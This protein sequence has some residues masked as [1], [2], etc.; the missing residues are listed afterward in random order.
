[1]GGKSATAPAKADI[2][3][4]KFAS[5]Q[6]ATGDDIAQRYHVELH[7]RNIDERLVRIAFNSKVQ[8]SMQAKITPP[9]DGV[10]TVGIKL[11]VPTN[12]AVAH[13]LP[14]DAVSLRGTSSKRVDWAVNEFINELSR[15]KSADAL[16]H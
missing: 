14:Q 6:I 3:I 12:P 13:L 5:K 10:I 9:V 8:K 7:I 16:R 11:D 15:L 1:M 4:V 2:E